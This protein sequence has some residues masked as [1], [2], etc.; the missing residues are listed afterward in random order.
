MKVPNFLPT[1]FDDYLDYDYFDNLPEKATWKGK[2]IDPRVWLFLFSMEYYYGY[3]GRDAEYGELHEDKKICVARKNRVA[4]SMDAL[5][6]ARKF[7]KYYSLDEIEDSFNDYYLREY[8]MDIRQ[9]HM[10]SASTK[11]SFERKVLHNLTDTHGL[12][13]AMDIIW[14]ALLVKLEEATTKEE[15]MD[16][17]DLVATYSVLSLKEYRVN[18]KENKKSS[19]LSS[20]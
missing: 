19:S 13:K 12:Q 14:E 9:L 7:D 8:N 11:V 18:K 1:V 15:K 17:L 16:V 2:E 3:F 10:T 20:K 5:N 4:N 6:Y